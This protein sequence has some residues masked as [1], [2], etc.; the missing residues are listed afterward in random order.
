MEKIKKY[1]RIKFAPEII[2]E[3]SEE[4]NKLLKDGNPTRFTLSVEIGDEEWNYDTEEEFLGAYRKCVSSR[5][6]KGG[7]G[8][9]GNV[10]L[11]ISY[12]AGSLGREYT[13]I[14]FEVKD[15]PTIEKIFEMFEKHAE[16]SKLPELPQPPKPPTEPTVEP[17]IF[18]GH[19]GSPLWKEL[20]DHLHEKHGYKVEFY[21]LGARAGHAVRDILDKM[22]KGSSFALL[23]MTGEDKMEDGKVRARDNVIHEIGLFQGKL[24]FNRA[25]VLLE[26]GTEEFSNIQGIDQI[27]F[28]K[29]NIK[30]TFGDVLATLKREFP[31]KE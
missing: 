25:I 2:R 11:S 29:G 23:V 10:Y 21:E 26:E 3:V 18:I 8:D 30:E 14:R 28:K 6:V 13:L 7:T 12:D 31:R 17:T 20:K 19:G 24:G 27:R 22:I 5:F 1:R 4:V 15:R 16:R 9:L